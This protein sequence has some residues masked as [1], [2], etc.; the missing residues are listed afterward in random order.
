MFNGELTDSLTLR[1][2]V[3]QDGVKRY[4]YIFYKL[5]VKWM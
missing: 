5:F 1:E 4:V 2:S 3:V